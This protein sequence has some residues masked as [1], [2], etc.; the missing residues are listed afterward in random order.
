[1]NPKN[2]YIREYL[3]VDKWHKAGYTGKRGLTLTAE[4][5]PGNDHSKKTLAV[6]HEIAPDREVRFQQFYDTPSQAQ[7]FVDGITESGA[8]TMYMSLYISGNRSKAGAEI[9]REGWPERFSFFAC[10]GNDGGNSHNAIIEHDNAWGVGAVDLRWS[11]MFGNGEPMPGAKML[12]IPADYT[13]EDDDVDFAA[14][15]NLYPEGSAARFSGTSCATPVLC[16]MAALVNDFFIE[17][18]G[19][20]LAHEAMYRFLR[21]HSE[22]I[23]DKGKDKYTGYGLPRLPDP[24]SIDLWEWQERTEESTVENE[25]TYTINDAGLV[26]AGTAGKR[27]ITSELILHHAAA[28]GSVKAI[29][30]AHLGRGWD[31]IGYH[32]YVRKDGTVWRGRPEDSIGAHTVGHN[33]VS[34]GVCFEGNFELDLMSEAQLNAG[35]WLIGNIVSRYPYISI[36]GHRDNDATACPGKNF[37]AELLKYKEAEN[38]TIPEFIN[39]L[40]DE[41]AYTIIEKA[42]RHAATLPLPTW[43]KEEYAEAVAAGIT[44]GETP[45]QFTPRY[46]TALMTLRA[47]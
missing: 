30:A 33:S 32:Y 1:M 13:S 22:D 36:S 21:E 27:A 47:K 10:A 5:I 28:N 26:F 34:I 38:M 2:D 35:L 42:Q 6:F 39:S 37:P 9:L 14:P 31:G 16:G 45:M 15:T 40:T 17:K 44:D 11:A 23:P 24:A 25:Y 18:T 20:P 7:I 12:I 41:Q 3:G 29:H 19:K 8:D 4:R 46:Q 43:A